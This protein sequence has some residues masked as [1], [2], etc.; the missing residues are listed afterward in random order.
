MKKVEELKKVLD[1]YVKANSLK[2]KVY[3]EENN[4]TISGCLYGAISLAIA[5]DS[6][7]KESY[8]V[9]RVI[10]MMLLDEFIKNNPTYDLENELKKGKEL[11]ELIFEARRMESNDSKLAFKYRMM[12]FILTNLIKTSPNLSNE[13]LIE[14]G[15]KC[16]NPKN[17][18]E[19]ESYKQVVR[20]YIFNSRLKDK[21]RSGWDQTHWNIDADR[22]ERIAEHIVSTI[23]LAIAL[24]SEMEYNEKVDYDRNIDLD[25]IIK[26][27]SIH[28]IGETLIGDITPFDGVTP[29]RKRE[30]EFDAVKDLLGNLKEK[31]E[32]LEL[33]SS[34]EAKI[35]NEAIFAYFCD[36]IE[37]DLQSKFYQ[38]T[39]QHRSLNDQKTNKVMNL[40]I[41]KKLIEE[42][43][44]TPFDIWYGYDKKIYETYPPFSEFRDLLTF[45]R[46]NNIIRNTLDPVVEKIKLTEEEYKFLTEQIGDMLKTTLYDNDIEAVT[47][48]NVQ[49]GNSDKGMIIIDFVI[50]ED[51]PYY[52]QQRITERLTE[53][54]KKM[55]FTEI[56]VYFRYHRI[57]DYQYIALNP[58]D[59]FRNERLNVSK[60]L[61]DKTG[62]I[63]RIHN[64]G[65]NTNHLYSF[66]TLEY[67][68]PVEEE[69]SKIMKK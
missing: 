7:F 62:R 42:G 51:A 46:D 49:G 15:I 55:N 44:K 21:N 26:T 8:N 11:Q 36:K 34:F 25:E 16:F 24:D 33:F 68:P 59:V 37:A 50:A 20:Y 38:D 66:Y 17:E 27:L 48:I 6:E 43:A 53:Q 18:S 57:S 65:N 54:F 39:F 10:K 22:I 63:T 56:E 61:L 60:I 19:Y 45:I 13:E 1:F 40:D 9:S 31:T 41:T 5:M 29:E 30:I 52:R 58:S 67:V 12:D 14:K 4:Y 3:D 32:L 23:Y 64:N 47:Q 2:T 28:E 69:I 35:S